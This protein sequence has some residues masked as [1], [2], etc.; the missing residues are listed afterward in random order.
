[1]VHYGKREMY[2]ITYLLQSANINEG[3]LYTADEADQ[4]SSGKS[5]NI[6]SKLSVL[7]L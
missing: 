3:S 7:E 1:M 5:R 4:G 2:K 6:Q